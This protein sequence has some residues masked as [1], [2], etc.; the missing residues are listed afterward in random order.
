MIPTEIKKSQSTPSRALPTADGGRLRE[1]DGWRAVSVMFVLLYHFA[2]YQHHGLIPRFYGLAHVIYYC[3]PLGVKIFFVISGFVICRLLI[4]E[5]RRYGMVSLKAFYYRRFFRIVPPL[6]AYLAIVSLLL[7]LG[8]V[9]EYRRSV[10]YAALFLNDFNFPHHGWLVGHTWSLAV[11]EQFYLLFPSLWVLT[12]RRWRST[13]LVGVFLFCMA[14]SLPEIHKNWYA[15]LW[16]DARQGF[17]CIS[18]GALMAVHEVRLRSMVVR[19]PAFFVLFV[20]TTLVLHPAGE[21]T[22][23]AGVYEGLL[24]PPAICL[25]LMYSLGCGRPLRVF[26]RNRLVEAVGITSY[27]IYLWQQL[28]TVPKEFLIGHGE[29]I[30]LLLPLLLLIVP[31]SYFLVERPAMRYGKSLSERA[32]RAG[33]GF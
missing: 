3:G 23:E 13:T 10:L 29:A 12:P 18:C 30:R 32:L 19:I 2:W 28:F 7:C 21:G 4:S 27:G 25:V 20:A 11:E 31:L 1:L 9:H 5:E 22:W 26:L 17:A 14:W 24:V 33:V 15:F 6:F 8:L 16:S